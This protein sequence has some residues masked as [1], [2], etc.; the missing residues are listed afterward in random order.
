M[1]HYS[2]S[3]VLMTVLT[4][5][6]LIIV[7]ALCFQS[8]KVLCSTGYKLLAVMLA[9]IL[10]RFIFPFELP[11]SRNILML[12][13][14]SRIVG[15]ILHPFLIIGRVRISVW[16]LLECIWVCGTVYQLYRLIRSYLV[17]NRFIS[18]YGRDVTAEEPYSSLLKRVCD[19]RKNNFRVLLVSSLDTPRQSG[20]FHPCILIPEKLTLSEEDLYYTICHE[21]AHYRHHDFLIK[22]GINILVALYWWNPLCYILREQADI[23]LEMRVDDKLVKNDLSV[24]R[25]YLA[26]LIHICNHMASLQDRT[27]EE[28]SYLYTPTA[29]RDSGD[30]SVRT[31]MMYG[32]KKP[33]LPL[34]SLSVL[35]TL[36]LYVV[37]YCFIFEA[38]Y[39]EPNPMMEECEIPLEDMI[40]I[41][42]V[43]GTYDLYWE[44]LFVEHISTLEYHEGVV[45][46]YNQ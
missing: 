27:I 10:L 1:L 34:F 3:T 38:S 40:A 41:P 25:E 30:L 9:F 28:P 44:D 6:L 18:R 8:K 37:S 24:R 22:L 20:C 42:L 17:F 32:K 19:N 11:F 13:A 36:L 35:L 46:I 39:A 15:S 26:T 31:H 23:I 7:V 12:E 29:L 16:F 43:D 33:S 5:N 45:V 14:L 21:A 4:S 2:F